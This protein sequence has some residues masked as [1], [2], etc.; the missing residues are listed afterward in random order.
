[1]E[2]PS[3]L[4]LKLS[5]RLFENPDKQ[6]QFLD[7]LMNPQPFNPAII[8]CKNQLNL[9]PFTVE[10]SINWQPDFVQRL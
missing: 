9:S 5:R 2:K 3:N 1:M 8:W 4:L 10:S 7:S 6:E